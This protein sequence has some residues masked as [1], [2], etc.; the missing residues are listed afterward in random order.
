VVLV[1]ISFLGK[2][3]SDSKLLFLSPSPESSTATKSTEATEATASESPT[4]A[5]AVA[6]K[7]TASATETIKAAALKTLESLARKVAT[8]AVLSLAI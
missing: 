5:K 3:M 7:S 6:A 8:R 4:A 1:S 2:K